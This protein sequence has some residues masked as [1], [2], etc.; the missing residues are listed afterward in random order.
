LGD[1]YR[2][3][4]INKWLYLGYKCSA[5]IAHNKIL[6]KLV[7]GLHKPNKQTILPQEAVENFFE[8]TSINKVNSLGGKFGQTLSEDFQITFMGQLAKIP[9]KEL[10]QK[11]DEKTG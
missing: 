7:C 2:G 6:A 3:V 8:I 10:V 11:Y 9:E 5:G 1:P 4:I